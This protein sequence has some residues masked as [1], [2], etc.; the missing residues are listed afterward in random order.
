LGQALAAWTP[1]CLP[2]IRAV[3]KMSENTIPP[4]PQMQQ[5][6]IRRQRIRNLLGPWLGPWLVG[7]DA[8]QLLADTDLPYS[9]VYQKT[10][11]W[12]DRVKH[13]TFTK[14]QAAASTSSG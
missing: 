8:M 5:E 10:R 13:A 1:E 4:T 14:T 2:C 11:W 3:Q 7:H 12:S 6:F 9:T